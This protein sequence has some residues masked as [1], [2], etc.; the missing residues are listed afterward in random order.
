MIR[1]HNTILLP[2][3]QIPNTHKQT[4]QFPAHSQTQNQTWWNCLEAQAK[5]SKLGFPEE[6][7]NSFSCCCC[8]CF[9]E[10]KNQTKVANTRPNTRPK[11]G[12]LL[13]LLLLLLRPS[14]SSSRLFPYSLDKEESKKVERDRTSATTNKRHI[15]Q[16]NPKKPKKKKA[17]AKEEEGRSRAETRPEIARRVFLGGW[18]GHESRLTYKPTTLSPQIFFIRGGISPNADFCFKLEARL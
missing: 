13:L 2:P 17:K 18:L 14:Y 1:S 4:N 7:G 3:R 15:Q 16:L 11:E 9:Q 6:S 10:T 5:G 8:C 12:I